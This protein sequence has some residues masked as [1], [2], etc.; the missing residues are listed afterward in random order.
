MAHDLQVFRLYFFRRTVFCT[1]GEF[2]TKTFYS[3]PPLSP[4]LLRL[5]GHRAKFFG[6]RLSLKQQWDRSKLIDYVRTWLIATWVGSA[7]SYGVSPFLMM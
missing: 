3:I 6:C 2:S 5:R 1:R 7:S 4:V